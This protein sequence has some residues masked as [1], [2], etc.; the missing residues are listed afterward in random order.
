VGAAV[1]I[2]VVGAEVGVRVGA[3]VVGARVGD[4]VV[5]RI[6]VDVPGVVDCASSQNEKAAFHAHR[7]MH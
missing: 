4:R 3:V 2:A 7:P 6:T 1:G 5:V